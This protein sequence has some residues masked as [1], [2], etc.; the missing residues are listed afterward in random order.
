MP[1]ATL[2]ET[3]QK[4][5]PMLYRNLLAMDTEEILRSYPFDGAVLM[6]GCDKSTPALLMGAA[7]A[8]RPIIYVPAGPMLTG[9]WHGE[10]LAVAPTCGGSG[11]K[12]APGP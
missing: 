2:S 1:V 12:S 8:N 6:G 11:T 7:S 4:P 9:H 10:T 3:F 5:T